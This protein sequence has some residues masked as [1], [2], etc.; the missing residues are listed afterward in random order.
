[1]EHA[2]VT[3]PFVSV[4]TEKKKKGTK[5]SKDFMQKIIVGGI[6]FKKFCLFFFV[7]LAATPQPQD[8]CILL[9]LEL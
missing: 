6:V 8:E 1:M 9:F 3:L 7:A 4:R 2:F 5:Y